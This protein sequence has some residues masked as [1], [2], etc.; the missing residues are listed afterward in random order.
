MWAR[1]NG[2]SADSKRLLSPTVAADVKLMQLL[3]V[4]DVSV[5]PRT[6]ENIATVLYC[7]DKIASVVSSMPRRVVEKV[8]SGLVLRYDHDQHFLVSTRPN[9]ETTQQE[10]DK[11]QCMTLLI[12][13]NAF[14]L[15]V[16][17]RL[18]RP[19][20]YVYWHPSEVVAER[21]D[22]ELYYYN[23]RYDHR[24]HH[25]DVL[26]HKDGP[27]DQDTHMA[28]SRLNRSAST[29]REARTYQKFSQKFVENGAHL[30]FVLTFPRG[31]KQEDIDLINRTISTEYSGLKK[32]GKAF[33]VGGDP[34]IQKVGM[35]LKDVQL[36]ET[37]EM[38]KNDIGLVFGFKP[39]QIGSKTGESFNSLEQYNKEF[40]QYPCMPIVRA[41]EQEY[42][43]KVVRPSERGRVNI[44]IDFN[45][46]MRGSSVDRAEMY[47]VL[48][49]H[50]GMTPNEML[51]MEGMNTYEGGNFRMLP[52]N[53][54]LLDKRLNEEE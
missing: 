9:P 48:L 4:G 24:A 17:D 28:K 8:D 34:T 18:G 35:P 29:F 10:F 6:I 11:M 31:T 15:I 21:I 49:Q 32:P 38:H 53:M 44:D 23:H 27:V 19:V 43:Y 1:F 42:S 54:D 12:W 40:V 3:E 7:V 5:S 20:A 26:H 30:G 33:A 37:R 52:A 45:G 46:L 51:E 2:K 41:L 36:I 16:R 50:G 47:R 13:G 14:S 25:M 22:G 39:G